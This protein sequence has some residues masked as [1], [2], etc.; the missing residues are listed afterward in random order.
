[1]NVV[2]VHGVVS[3]APEVRELADGS[4]VAQLEVSAESAGGRGTVPIAW[5]SPTEPVPL[6]GTEVVV[7][8]YLRR[9]YFRVGGATQSRTEIVADA[10]VPARARARV[11]KAVGQVLQQVSDGVGA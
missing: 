11:R 10:V 2:V 1:M 8:G 4:S 7:T 5:S 9:R 6:E 3:R